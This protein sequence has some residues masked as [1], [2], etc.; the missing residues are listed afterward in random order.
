MGTRA[1]TMKDRDS[2][3]MAGLMAVTLPEKDCSGYA[4]TV[5]LTFWPTRI[6]PACTPGIVSRRRSGSIFRSVTTAVDG[7]TYSPSD[8]RRWLM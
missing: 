3:E 2:A 5:A 7:C 6:C 8:T 1:S 4:S